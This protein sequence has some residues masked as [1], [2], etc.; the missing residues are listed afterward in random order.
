M[1]F[2]LNVIK[3]LGGFKSLGYVSGIPIGGDDTEL[4]IRAFR[5]GCK[6][7][8]SSRAILIHVVDPRKMS[9]KYTLLK[10]STITYIYKEL[11]PKLGAETI[12]GYIYSWFQELVN[13]VRTSNYFSKITDI[14]LH[15]SLP[16]MN[17]IMHK[18]L[19]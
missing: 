11:Q 6:I 17:T 1:S 8:Y 12:L 10:Y 5:M 13:I 9:K 15:L 19:E 3:K 4:C 7:C 18:L 16:I 14:T 2:K